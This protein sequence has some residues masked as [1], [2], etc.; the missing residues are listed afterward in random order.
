MRFLKHDNFIVNLDDV[1]SIHRPPKSLEIILTTKTHDGAS[2]TYSMLYMNESGRGASFNALAMN[3]GS[4]EIEY[5]EL[6]PTLTKTVQSLSNDSYKTVYELKNLT[7]EL[8]AI[9]K[10]IKAM[11]LEKDKK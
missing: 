2:R 3:L 5:N 7:K 11:R 4:V 1:I 6:V 10:E 9:R 8:T